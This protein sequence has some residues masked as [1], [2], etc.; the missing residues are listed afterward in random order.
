[1]P[2]AC[3][4]KINSHHKCTSVR[5]GTLYRRGCVLCANGLFAEHGS[6]YHS[7]SA[8]R[9]RGGV[10]CAIELAAEQQAGMLC[11]VSAEHRCH[12]LLHPTDT[13]PRLK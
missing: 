4:H 3:K 12:R 6:C 9:L 13:A 11:A 10:L 5:N 1:M 8:L 7:G 2:P